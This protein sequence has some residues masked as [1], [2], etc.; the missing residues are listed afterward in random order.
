VK[1]AKDK[2]EEE[3]ETKAHVPTDVNHLKGVVGIPDF[4]EKAIKNN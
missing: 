4:W 3:E 2:E 1:S